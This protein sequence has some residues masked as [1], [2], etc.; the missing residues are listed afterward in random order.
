MPTLTKNQ[1]IDIY[2]RI[3]ASILQGLVSNLDP[4]DIDN[5]KIEIANE[6]KIISDYFYLKL[7]LSLDQIPAV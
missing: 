1:Q 7:K 2:S 4:S 6:C 5:D 3:Y